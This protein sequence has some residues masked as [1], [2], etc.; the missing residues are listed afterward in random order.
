MCHRRSPLAAVHWNSLRRCVPA[1]NE[2]AIIR[3]NGVRTLTVDVDI[4]MGVLGSDVQKQ[5]ERYVSTLD[6]PG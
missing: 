1:W 5:V 2:G 3:R 6:T 4:G